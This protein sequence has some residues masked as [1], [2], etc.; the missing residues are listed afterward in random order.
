MRSILIRFYRRTRLAQAALWGPT[1]LMILVLGLD[2]MRE[3]IIW[4]WA[5][6]AALAGLHLGAAVTD[7]SPPSAPEPASQ[8]SPASSAPP[9]PA[10]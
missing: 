8:R 10:S 6:S 4:V 9:P 2:G 5:L 1:I 7:T 3:F